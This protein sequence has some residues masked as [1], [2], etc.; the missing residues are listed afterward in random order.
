MMKDEEDCSV[1][2]RSHDGLG[3]SS[4]YGMSRAIMAGVNRQWKVIRSVVN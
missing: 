4:K 2:R 1:R 3:S